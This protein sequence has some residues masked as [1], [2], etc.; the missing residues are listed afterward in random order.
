MKMHYRTF[1]PGL[2]Q[3]KNHLTSKAKYSVFHSQNRISEIPQHFPPLESSD[4]LIKRGK[5]SKF[6][7]VALDENLSWKSCIDA[8]TFSKKIGIIFRSCD[9]MNKNC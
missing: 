5:T 4:T 3:M 6:L 8:S 1:P 7:G 2:K 9:Y